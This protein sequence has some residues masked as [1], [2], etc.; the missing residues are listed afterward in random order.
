[1][2]DQIPENQVKQVWVY[3]VYSTKDAIDE[4]LVEILHK[5]EVEE[6]NLFINIKMLI[7]IACCVLGYISYFKYDLTNKHG[8]VCF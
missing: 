3:D 5:K 8:S 7:G 1:M 4:E 2:A 6:R